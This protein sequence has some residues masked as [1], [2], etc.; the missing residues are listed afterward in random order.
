MNGNAKCNNKRDLHIIH[1]TTY[2]ECVTTMDEKFSGQNFRESLNF[3][4]VTIKRIVFIAPI[5]LIDCQ[6]ITSLSVHE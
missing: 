3:A 1:Y 5:A 4:Y 2:N 6:I